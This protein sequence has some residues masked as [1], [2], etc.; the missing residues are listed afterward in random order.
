M[1]GTSKDSRLG[2]G[3]AGLS[4]LGA[5]LV[6]AFGLLNGLSADEPVGK[7]LCFLAAALAFGLLANAVFRD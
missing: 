5:L 6:G 4:A 3:V 2:M 7:G 1:T